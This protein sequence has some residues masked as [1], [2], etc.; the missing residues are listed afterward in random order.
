MLPL[1]VILLGGK[2]H[3]R[4]I[5]LGW[6]Q[7]HNAEAP[8]L[9]LMSYNVRLFDFYLSSAAKDYRVRD[10][11]INYL[12]KENPDVLCLQEYFYTD[13]STD[14]NM[15]K[16]LKDLLQSKGYHERVRFQQN[17]KRNFGVSIFSKYPIVSKGEVSFPATATNYCIYADI[18]VN[19]DTLRVYNTHL[20]SVKIK[21]DDVNF[22]LDDDEETNLLRLKTTVRK[23]KNAYPAR[24][25][26]AQLILKH[27]AA[28]PFP[29]V[30]CGD[31]N[32][33]PISYTYNLFNK[34]YTDAFRNAGKGLGRTYAGKLPAGR[35]DYIWHS[36]SLNSKDFT[37]QKSQ[38]SDHY[39]ISAHIIFKP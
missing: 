34:T 37:V 4:Y 12:Q 22:N 39:A 33:P 17:K 27:A 6:G 30:I 23:L 2:L 3:F 14:F 35:I 31:F 20:Q 11:I 36:T 15:K 1:V 32:D 25:E 28:S 13:G 8:S 24:A 26:Q 16:E 5:N 29:V 7:Q 21:E 9:K 19:K 18:K 38:F 10:S